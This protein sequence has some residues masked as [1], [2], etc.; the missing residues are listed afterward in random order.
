MLSSVRAGGERNRAIASLLAQF[1]YLEAEELLS[2]PTIT[3]AAYLEPLPIQLFGMLLV[4][5]QEAILPEH[6][7]TVNA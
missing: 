2:T 4:Q 1:G 6:R 5:C 7:R 3:S